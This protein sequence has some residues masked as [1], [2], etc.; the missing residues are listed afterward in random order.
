MNGMLGHARAREKN[1]NGNR[2][3]PGKRSDVE[4]G[5][6]ASITFGRKVK[7]RLD[8]LSFPVNQ[9]S[10]VILEGG[11]LGKPHNYRHHRGSHTGIRVPGRILRWNVCVV[12]PLTRVHTAKQCFILHGPTPFV[13]T[14][15]STFSRS[16]NYRIVRMLKFVTFGKC[17]TVCSRNKICL[18]SFT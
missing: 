9:P 2:I 18:N 16:A 10:F 12:M 6:H 11:R 4:N 15:V 8:L 13:R 17:F 7:S 14:F 3:D 1:I 5:R